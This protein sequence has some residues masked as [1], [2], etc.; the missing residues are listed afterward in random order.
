M[1]PDVALISPYPQLGARHGGASGVASY[2][3][4]LAHA[5]ADAG[6]HPLVIAPHLD[7][8]P[9]RSQDGPVDVHRAFRIG[10]ANAVPEA[11]AAARASGA[12]VL[13]LQ[14]EL[15]LYG[16][17]TASIGLVRALATER[18]PTV[19]TMHQVV[20]PSVVTAEYTRLHRVAVPAPAARAGFI[21]LQRAVP[22]LADATIVHERPFTRFVRGARV[23]PHGVEPA[24]AAGPDVRAAARRA[25]ELP[26]DR[27]VALCFGFVAP[28]K[29]LEVALDAAA[30]AGPEV[31]LVIAGGEHPRL[32]A[33]GDGYLNELRGRYEGHARFTGFVPDADV[34]AWFQA[35]D[36]AVFPYPEPH[37]S[38][39]AFA[40]A[41]AHGTPALV[42]PR[43]ADA[44][45][46]GT[47]ASCPL[48]PVELAE[49]LRALAADSQQ[50]DRMR[51]AT[52]ALAAD[53][54]WHE[55]A[56]AHRSIYSDV[57]E[58]VERANGSA[59]R[60]LRAA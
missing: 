24:P 48:D 20:D 6:A 38:S 5:L 2:T 4:N 17:P 25:L 10:S 52:T 28:Y 37:A 35:A 36:V 26:D 14:H 41:L 15:F 49:R 23:V 45:G 12:D 3:A 46:V 32:A 51:T 55:V 11:F 59:R 7:G 34:A 19:V 44:C 47:D 16:G 53:R 57:Y 40:L 18:M 60:R 56:L 42:S 21:A 30:L 9:A 8:Q 31:L 29:G 33:Q 27:L 13:H 43:L 39:G 50:R 22:R 58:E 1:R 54:S